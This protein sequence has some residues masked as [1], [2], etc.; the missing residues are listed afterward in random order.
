MAQHGL[1]HR[2]VLLH[3]SFLLQ[4]APFSLLLSGLARNIAEQV[5][6]NARI[7]AGLVVEPRAMVE[8]IYRIM[9]QA[10][11]GREQ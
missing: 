6:D 8:R 4:G 10:L 1:D 11:A 2:Q 7:S 3:G 9:E 5:F